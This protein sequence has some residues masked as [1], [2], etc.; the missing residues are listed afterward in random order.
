VRHALLARVLR[1]Q[2]RTPELDGLARST[3]TGH[4]LAAVA[5]VAVRAQA[6]LGAGDPAGAAAHLE[7]GGPVVLAPFLAPSSLDR[8]LVLTAAGRR[9][10][11]VA[12]TRE[13][14]ETARRWRMPGL[15]TLAGDEV[16]PLLEEV[17]GRTV[18][19]ALAALDGPAGP[20]PVPVPGGAEVLSGREVEVLRLLADGASN[21]A[22]AA[23][24]VVSENTIKTHVR[25]VLTKLG[26]GSRGE[27][28]ALARR[29]HL[30]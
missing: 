18:D 23:R 27:A 30:I 2:G 7:R 25:H 10:E 28:V 19:A 5:A 21:R 8:A 6:A 20:S 4:P 22:V 24:L 14:V 17:G 29:H 1:R 9:A 12:A 13:V 11:A 15:L 3:S 26:A 16:R